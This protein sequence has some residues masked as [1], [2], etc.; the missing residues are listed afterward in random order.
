M[1]V[2]AAFVIGSRRAEQKR[3]DNATDEGSRRLLVTLIFYCS[4]HSIVIIICL[5]YRNQKLEKVL[6]WR[7]EPPPVGCTRLPCTH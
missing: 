1:Y 7:A 4:F 2:F 6:A 3:Q 5:S